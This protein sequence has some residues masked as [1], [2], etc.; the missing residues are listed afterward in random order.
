MMPASQPACVFVRDHASMNCGSNAGT[1]EYPARLRISAAHIAATTGVK[2]GALL[3]LPRGHDSNEKT[4]AGGPGFS[5]I[6]DR[7][8]GITIDRLMP[9]KQRQAL[10]VH[11][12]MRDI[13]KLLDHMRDRLDPPRPIRPIRNFLFDSQTGDANRVLIDMGAGPRACLAKFLCYSA[14]IRLRFRCRMGRQNLVK[15]LIKR[16]TWLARRGLVQG[17]RVFFRC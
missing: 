10:T 11:T 3:D 7:A 6:G 8:G 12:L 5:R 15:S 4:P 17:T 13:H 14:A 2:G 9:S 1:I 16:K